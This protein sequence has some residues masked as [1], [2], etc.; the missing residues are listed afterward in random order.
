MN[1]AAML[2]LFKISK[3]F[4]VLNVTN[5][6]DSENP[7]IAKLIRKI[8]ASVV[9]VEEEILTSGSFAIRL[10]LPELN[11]LVGPPGLEPGTN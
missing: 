3:I 1:I 2:F 5:Y 4:S 7:T 9:R 10:S 8:E 6:L 11:L